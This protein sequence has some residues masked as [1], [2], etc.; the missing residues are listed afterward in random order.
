[1]GFGSFVKG[2]LSSAAGGF[3]LTDSLFKTGSSSAARNASNASKASAEQFDKFFEMIRPSIETGQEYLGKLGEY[4]TFG[5]LN[6]LY[7]EAQGS[8]LAAD[9]I[10]DRRQSLD[11][12]LASSGLR[13]SG[14]ALKEIANLPTAVFS[15]LMD[16]IV[17]N[18]Q[19]MATIGLG[20]GSNALGAISGS[21]N[22]TNTASEF[23]MIPS[24]NKQ[25]LFGGL[26]SM[27]GALGGAALL[28]DKRLKTN[29]KKIGEIGPLNVYEW[30]WKDD[31]MNMVM[32]AGFIAQEVQEVYPQHVHTFEIG[33]HELLAVDYDS[34]LSEAA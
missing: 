9:M 30:D 10:S 18:T 34:V 12:Y 5:G 20:Q 6:D 23:G 22:A 14:T 11:G 13:R 29:I 4:S 21:A 7:S 19:N 26:L 31:S 1:M 2:A 17:G 25:N 32:R 3:G 27:G 16:K 8:Q 24:Q 33:G 28:S 15:G